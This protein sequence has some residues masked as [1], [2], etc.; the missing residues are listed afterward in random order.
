MGSGV[1]VTAVLGSA[2][3]LPGVRG[4]GVLRLYSAEAERVPYT[5]SLHQLVGNC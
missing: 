3:W 5:V 2:A 1:Y 4:G